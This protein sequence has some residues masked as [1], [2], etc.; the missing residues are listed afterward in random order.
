MENRQS[1]A[2]FLFKKSTFFLTTNTESKRREKKKTQKIRFVWKLN[3][4]IS[5][6]LNRVLISFLKL[7]WSVFDTQ[8]TQKKKYFYMKKYKRWDFEELS[9]FVS[10]FSRFFLHLLCMC[11][12]SFILFLLSCLLLLILTNLRR[13]FLYLFF[14]C[15][16][17]FQAFKLFWLSY[18][19]SFQ[20]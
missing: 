11:Y 20:N 19:F 5:V 1:V 18:G 16:W 8:N 10:T 17:G 4:I 7:T 6:D 12:S 2:R 3:D 9:Y 14:F 15:S 13:F